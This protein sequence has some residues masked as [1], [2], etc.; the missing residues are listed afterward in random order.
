LATANYRGCWSVP[1]L[2]TASKQRGSESGHVTPMAGVLNDRLANAVEIAA[3]GNR[4]P[5]SPSDPQ[6]RR[7]PLSCVALEKGFG[8][9]EGVG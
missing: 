9:L 7:E 3:Q 8:R 1:G 4:T 2:R 6:A 5:R